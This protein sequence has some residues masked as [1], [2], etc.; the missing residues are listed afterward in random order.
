M[1]ETRK[2]LQI[3]ARAEGMKGE[4]GKEVEAAVG[5]KDVSGMCPAMSLPRDPLGTGAGDAPDMCQEEYG[6]EASPL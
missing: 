6:T 5:S 2:A 4:M 1:S 3:D